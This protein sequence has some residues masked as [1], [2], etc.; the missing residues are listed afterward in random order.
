MLFPF[1]GLFYIGTFIKDTGKVETPEQIGGRLFAQC[2]ACHNAN[3]SGSEAGGIGRPLWRGEV[4]KTFLNPAEQIAFIRHGSCD[5]G[6]PYG[7]AKRPGGQHEAK[8]GMPAFGDQ[9]ISNEQIAYLVSYERNNLSGKPF[10]TTTI[11]KAP[12]TVPTTIDPTSICG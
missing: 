5:K 3:G 2:Q 4:E 9:Q 12:T 1:W 11:G 8:G 10:P 7:N 6:T